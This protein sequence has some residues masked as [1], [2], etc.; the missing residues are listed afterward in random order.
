GGSRFAG[1]VRAGN[2][3]LNDLEH[4]LTRLAVEY[5]DQSGLRRLYDRGNRFAVALDVH[6]HRLRSQV[7]IPQV[8]MNELAMPEQLAGFGAQSNQRVGVP[9]IADSLAA[10]EVRACRAGRNEHESATG[11]DR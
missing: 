9:V 6:E 2:R 7:V 1:D 11:I 8:V 5:E 4:G 3:T 10:V